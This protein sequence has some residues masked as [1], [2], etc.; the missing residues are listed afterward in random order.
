MAI[1]YKFVPHK[2]KFSQSWFFLISGTV[3]TVQ[4]KIATDIV[5][6]PLQ[7]YLLMEKIIVRQNTVSSF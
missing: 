1:K 7:K 6:F 2:F 4:R 3:L 5:I